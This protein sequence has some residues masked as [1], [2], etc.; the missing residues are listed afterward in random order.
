MDIAGSWST[1]CPRG[2]PRSF[3]SKLLCTWVAINI[4]WWIELFLPRCRMPLLNFVRFLAAHF[5]RLSKSL[6][7]AMPPSIISSTPPSS[8]SPA[9][10]LRVHSVPL[11]KPLLKMLHRSVDPKDTLLVIALQLDF[12]QFPSLGPGCSGSFQSISLL[13]QLLCEVL[14][15]TRSKTLLLSRYIISTALLLSIRQSFYCR[16]LSPWCQALFPLSD[17]RLTTPLTFLSLICLE[18]ISGNCYSITL[19]G[20]EVRLTGL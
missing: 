13:V 7:M 2:P 1:W 12:H 18:M 15:E 19:P 14:I 16:S 17:V 20:T 4:H 11:S 3:P 6:W 5:S 8:M 9:Y 10:L